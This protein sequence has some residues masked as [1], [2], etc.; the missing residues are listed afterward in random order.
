M[1]AIQNSLDERKRQVFDW[2]NANIKDAVV[3]FS[4]M[5]TT[6][7]AKRMTLKGAINHLIKKGLEAEGFK[8]VA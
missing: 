5:K 7:S 1:E 3:K 4:G 2:E 8:S 6:S